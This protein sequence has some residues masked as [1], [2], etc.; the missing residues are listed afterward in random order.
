M[1][2]VAC[3]KKKWAARERERERLPPSGPTDDRRRGRTNSFAFSCLNLVDPQRGSRLLAPKP[4]P[5]R[6]H[7]FSWKP[8][9]RQEARHRSDG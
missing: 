4:L 7:Q 1:C 6:V 2:F 5:D 9:A 8:R 3:S